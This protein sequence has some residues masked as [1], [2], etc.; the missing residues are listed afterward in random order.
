VS[1]RT[2]DDGSQI[3]IRFEDTGIGMEPHEVQRVFNAFSQGDHADHGQSHRFGG[4]GLGLA[5]SRKLVE[6]H[7]GRI[8]ATSKGKDQGSTFT[9]HLPL[10]AET[11]SSDDQASPP[12]ITG[13]KVSVHSA[14]RPLGRIL[15]IEDHES[16]RIPLCRLLTRKGYIVVA[17]AS[18]ADALSAVSNTSFDLV[19]SDIGLPD[20][21]GFALM[22]SLRDEHGLRGIALTGY[23]MEADIARG[24][25]VGFVGHLTKPISVNVLERALALALPSTTTA[26]NVAACRVKPGTSSK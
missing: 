15:L 7:S 24:A 16:T 26:T 2:S 23:G 14:P 9:V 13:R 19:L 5:I 4:L 1:S 6:L 18:A 20:M 11:A 21:D 25:D 17:V 22:R 8:E 10:I 3:I 12:L